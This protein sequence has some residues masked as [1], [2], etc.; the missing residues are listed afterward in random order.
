MENVFLAVD[1]VFSHAGKGDGEFVEVDGVVIAHSQLGEEACDVASGDDASFQSVFRSVFEGDRDGVFLRALLF[2][3]E[4]LVAVD[5]VG[6]DEAPVLDA[7]EAVHLFRCI[8][9]GIKSSDDGTHAG[10]YDVVDGD[11]CFFDDFQGADVGD[12]FCSASA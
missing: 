11:A 12:A 5:S 6:E 8:A 4:F 3:E 2:D 1:Q 7:Y 10:P 9:D